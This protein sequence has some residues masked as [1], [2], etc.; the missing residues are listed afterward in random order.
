MLVE[1]RN[2]NLD[3]ECRNVN[4]PARRWTIA[5]CRFCSSTHRQFPLMCCNTHCNTYCH[6]RELS[7]FCSSISQ[8][9]PFM[10]SAACCN[11]HCNT[12]CVCSWIHQHSY[13]RLFL[14]CCS[15][16][17]SVCCSQLFLFFDS[18]TGPFNGV[19]VCF[20]ISITY[21]SLLHIHTR[22]LYTYIHAFC[23]PI[24]TF[25]VDIPTRF[26][27]IYSHISCSHTY[28]NF[29]HVHTG[30]FNA[31]IRLFLHFNGSLY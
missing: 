14:H 15:V 6:T 16:C 29:W 28:T 18:S 3:M 13:V 12:H 23:T 7:H 27:H 1:C 31:C 5:A 24:F 19:Y 17:C 25:L 2:E 11:T 4:L 22:L 26:L 21:R 20:Y 8:Q 9:D 30:L 10:D